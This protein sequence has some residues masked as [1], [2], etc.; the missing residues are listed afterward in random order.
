MARALQASNGS[1]TKGTN[2]AMTLHLTRYFG[3]H[4]ERMPDARMCLVAVLWYPRKHNRLGYRYAS[5]RWF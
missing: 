5:L 4:F 1:K 3:I 2:D